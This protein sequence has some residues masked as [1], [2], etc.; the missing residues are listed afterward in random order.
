MN[1]T[2]EKSV[3]LEERMDRLEQLIEKM[4]SDHISLDESFALYKQG[5]SEIKEAGEML[6][7]IEK[8]MLVMAPNGNL[9]EF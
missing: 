4:E 8:E 1:H 7:A 5:I 2:E 9:E 3:S 6:D